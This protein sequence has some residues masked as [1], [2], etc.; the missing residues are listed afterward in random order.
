M[1]SRA[2]KILMLCFLGV[3]LGTGAAWYQVT[4]QQFDQSVAKLEPAAGSSVAGAAIGGPFS[5]T[6]HNG[7]S[8]SE[9]DYAGSY[10]LVFFGFTYCPDICPT[11]LKKISNV[12]QA[13]GTKADSVQTLFISVD[14]DRDTPSVMKQYVSMFDP[15]I[16]GLTG[17]K[18]QVK[19]AQEAY[20]VYAEKFNDPALTEYTMNHSAYTFF[21]AP[22]GELIDLF[23]TGDTPSQMVKTMLESL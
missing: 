11:E 17:T 16:V 15:R 8:V 4:E 13:L 6:D 23:T 7:R 5:L 20:K 1:S 9:K 19:A 22:D 18:D 10:K 2:T 12:L 21:L 3:I 14:P